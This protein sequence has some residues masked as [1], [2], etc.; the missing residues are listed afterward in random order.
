[1][2]LGFLG[3]PLVAITLFSN[4][5][6]ANGMLKLTNLMFTVRVQFQNSLCIER[7]FAVVR[8]VLYRRY[9]LLQYRM[10]FC[11]VV[12]LVTILA[13]VPQII[14]CDNDL[15]SL[16]ICR[17]YFFLVFFLNLFC[18]SSLLR[19]LKQPSPG[20]GERQGSNLIKKMAF[21]I[22][23]ILQVTAFVGY[24]PLAT[25]YCM[26]QE[27]DRDTLCILQPLAYSV[28]VWLGIIHPLLYLRRAA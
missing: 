7:Y 28:M 8:P 19:A 6:F 4:K 22:V 20:G 23:L 9:K 27:M 10:S 12:W 16:V 11:C 24:L 1:M 3:P 17:I 25:V 18:C 26:V 13:G 2:L 21:T 14:F 15:E 5:V